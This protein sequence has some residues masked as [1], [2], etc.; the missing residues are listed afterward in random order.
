MENMIINH[1]AV[2]VAAISD[3]LVGAIWF[4]PLMFYKPWLKETKLTE[5]ILKKGN[6]AITYGLAFVLALIIS[7]NLAAF[8][9]EPSTD[10][11]WGLTAGF[12][13]GVWAA[14]GF[15]TIALFEKKTLKYVLIDCGYLLIA[16]TLK[17]MIIG[18][19]R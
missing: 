12:L 7:Y 4:S 17:G 5:E 2:F 11:V 8:L 6:P 13:A 15:A 14:A 19:W 10:T 16:F 9:G 18:A 1:W 3:F